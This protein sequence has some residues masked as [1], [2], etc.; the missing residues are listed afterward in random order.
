M[1]RKMLSKY[2]IFS[3]VLFKIVAK[4]T[5]GGVKT[6]ELINSS[7]NK[8]AHIVAETLGDTLNYVQVE[9]VIDTLPH[10]FTE[11]EAKAL[12]DSLIDTLAEDKAETLGDTL[13]YM[14]EKVDE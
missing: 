6:E 2:T 1:F 13:P 12:V 8:L 3:T 9:A 7:A 14:V 10:T 5:L 4:Y 11:M